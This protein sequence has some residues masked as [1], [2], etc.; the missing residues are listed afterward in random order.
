MSILNK[1][2]KKWKQTLQ[3]RKDNYYDFVLSLDNARSVYNTGNLVARCLTSYI[4]VGKKG[5]LIEGGGVISLNNYS[6]DGAINSGLVL[7]NIGF[8]G[9]DTM[10]VP[11]DKDTIT[12]DEFT[13]LITT[14]T[15][16]IDSGDTRL[17]LQPVSGNT[18]LYDY[19]TEVVQ[20]SAETVFKTYYK[21]NGGFLQ[22]FYK[23][24]NDEYQILPQYINGAWTLEFVLRPRSDYEHSGYTL[25]DVYP[26]NNG[27][28]FYMGS[29]A[30]NKFVEYYDVD[31]S[32]F[33]WRDG[34]ND[35]SSG[36][37]DFVIQTSEGHAVES[38]NETDIIT[39]NGHLIYD[40]TCDGYTTNTWKQGDKL[41]LRDEKVYTEEN[42]YP[43]MNRTCTGKTTDTLEKYI[44][45]NHLGSTNKYDVKKDLYSNAFALK[46][47]RDFEE[48]NTYSIGYKYLVKDC[49]SE[50]GYTIK[51]EIGLPNT[52]VDGEWCVID[53]VFK[54]L[55]GVTDDC[56]I[57]LGQRKMKM[58]IYVNGYLKFISQ[59]LPEFNFTQLDDFCDKQEGVAYNLS[60]G[61]GS[62]GLIES[63]WY[64][65]FGGS[66]HV[67]PI[68]QN[69]AGSFIGDMASFK[70]Y[71][72]QL[73]YAEIL[74]NC[75]Y[76]LANVETGETM[77]KDNIIYYGLFLTPE[78]TIR[79]GKQI[80]SM[81]TGLR[82]IYPAA[83]KHYNTSFF[84]IYSKKFKGHRPLFFTCG[85]APMVMIDS[86]QII[87]GTPCIVW[88]SAGRYDDTTLLTIMSENI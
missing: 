2:K 26:S 74:N 27:I 19:E 21:L 34:R 1:Y 59:E 6:Y 46:L 45:E 79:E 20:D 24:C 15:L 60:L 36:E 31:L 86:E 9:I 25:N 64:N 53:V 68:E 44:L 40:R 17:L 37:T 55:D 84:V 63:V 77:I 82:T 33:P 32:E 71:N 16:T 35:V 88:Q 14:S 66:K 54:I 72:C 10:L 50:K 29:R 69:F 62:Q 76:E 67:F 8:T 83:S 23:S 80:T 4:D 87:N 41:L 38:N 48:S 47:Y 22:G 56:G 58:F 51:E 3:L 75:Y 73:Q 39:D 12:E 18:K 52:I 11:F 78:D 85:G 5:C 70:F 7:K 43:I 28:F 13:N 65:N 57:P 30:E 81:G 61:G 42:L 49:D